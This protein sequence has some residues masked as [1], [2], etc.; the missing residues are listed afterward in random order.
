[1]L[2]RSYSTAAVILNT[3]TSYT[4]TRVA[5]IDDLLHLA[6]LSWVDPDPTSSDT[7]QMIIGADL[8]HDL[9][10]DERR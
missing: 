4:P 7:I 3:L 1:M 9:T 10:L 2:S 5:N 8:Y 6:D